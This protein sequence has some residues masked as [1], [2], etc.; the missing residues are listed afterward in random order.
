MQKLIYAFAVAAVGVFGA[1]PAPVLAGQDTSAAPV[2]MHP[3]PTHSTE[4]QTSNGAMMQQRGMSGDMMQHC[5]E[6]QQQMSDL[7]KQMDKLRSEVRHN[8]PK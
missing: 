1:A 5:Q 3:M 4:S 7:R 2:Q 6:M 8:H